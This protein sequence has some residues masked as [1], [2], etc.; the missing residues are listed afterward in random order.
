MPNWLAEGTTYLLAKTTETANAKNY[1]PITCLSTFYKI[2]TSMLTDRMY[3]FM[4][5]NKLFPLE[6]KG[7][8]KGS[9]GCKD[10]LLINR[11]LMENCQ[12][13]PRN[14]SMAWIE[15]RKAFGSVSHGRMLK[16]LDM[17]KLSPTIINFLQYNMG[18]WNTSFRFTN[19]NGMTKTENL[20][21]K[22]GIFIGNS[23]SPLLFCISLIPLSIQLN[24][25]GYGYQIMGKSINRL[26]YMDDLKLF[27]RNDNV[28]A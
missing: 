5:A 18:L 6:Q 7:C 26:F 8:K 24:S 15:Y 16:A 11:M 1:R 21:I 20:Q 14:L 25:A 2:L 13:N 10:Q 23:L 28:T 22:C 12:R 27:A 4:E 9:Y 3:T 19:A 17:F